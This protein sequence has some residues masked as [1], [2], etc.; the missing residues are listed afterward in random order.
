MEKKKKTTE[1]NVENVVEDK[2]LEEKPKEK[3]STKPRKLTKV[4]RVSQ[5]TMEG[6]YIRTFPSI[7]D[8]VDAMEI[9]SQT[10][11]D[12]INGNRY[13]TGGY[14]WAYDSDMMEKKIGR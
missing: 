5:Y 8:A 6:K 2:T 1:K 14:L 7:K 11:K 10:I 13:Q 3:K 12:Y 4:D 9:S